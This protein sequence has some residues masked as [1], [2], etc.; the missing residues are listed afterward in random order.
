MACR[1]VTSCPRGAQELTPSSPSSDRICE[2]CPTGS[3]KE[4]EGAGRC[5]PYTQCAA[6]FEEASPPSASVDRVCIECER[7]S[8]FKVHGDAR[9]ASGDRRCLQCQRVTVCGVGERTGTLPTYI[10]DRACVACDGQYFFSDERGRD[11]C[12]PVV[13][14]GPGEEETEAPSPSSDRVCGACSPGT[15]KSEAGQRTS[16]SPVSDCA[17]GTEEAQPPTPSSD[18]CVCVYVCVCLCQSW[19]LLAALVGCPYESLTARRRAGSARHVSLGVR[20]SAMGGSSRDVCWQ[21]S[22]A[23]AR[24]PRRCRAWTKTGSVARATAGA[25]SRTSPGWTGASSREVFVVWERARVCHTSSA[26][27]HGRPTACV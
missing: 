25:R 19:R 10:A 26:R 17:P 20:S 7:G 24:K 8:T 22:A 6:G 3:V 23:L 5:V 9:C 15:F 13:E 11:A 2:R 1:R 16:C 21:P 27:H 12:K 4:V 18:R 14:C